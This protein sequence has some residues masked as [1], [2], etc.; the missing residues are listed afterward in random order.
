MKSRINF[1][2]SYYRLVGYKAGALLPVL[3]TPVQLLCS[4]LPCFRSFVCSF[5]SF[6]PFFLA[7]SRCSHRLPTTITPSTRSHLNQST[8]TTRVHSLFI[9]SLSL[10][11]FP[12]GRLSQ[13]F[14]VYILQYPVFGP[15]IHPYGVH[16][17]HTPS[18]TI[19]LATTST[20]TTH[21]LPL[22]ALS[23]SPSPSSSHSHS[24]LPTSHPSFIHPFI[25]HPSSL[26]SS[27]LLSLS[28]SL[29]RQL[30]ACLVC[31]RCCASELE[32]LKFLRRGSPSLTARF[33]RH[34]SL[35]VCTVPA[36]RQSSSRV[37]LSWPAGV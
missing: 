30:A 13:Y 27:F 24:P 1:V 34:H 33:S 18:R 4:F 3:C 2:S 19:S 35:T 14:P 21:H 12:V 28:L 29:C 26:S 16:T 6:V 20:T 10:P 22:T 11:L 31:S 8:H 9:L 36:T 23:P 7:G 15:Y 37:S 17:N 25:H 32:F 5:D